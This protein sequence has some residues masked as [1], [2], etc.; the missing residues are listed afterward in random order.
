MASCITPQW[1]SYAPQ[2][3][4]TVNQSSSTDTSVTLSW[5]LEYISAY[6]ASSSGARAYTVTIDGATA[7]SGSY[8]INGVTGTRTIASGTKTVSKS[9][10]ARSVSF[11]VSFAFNLTWSGVRGNTKEASG[12]ISIGAKTS[13]TV[14]YNA[15]GGS[16]APGSQTKWYG[17]T[18]TLSSTRPSRTGYSFQGW[19]TSSGG[20]VSYSPGGSYTSNANVTLYAVW[21][22]NTYTVTFNA[23]G[24]SGGPGSQTKT[25]GV[26]LTI[27]STVPTR[28]NYSF[29]G[30]G[31]SSGATSVAYSPGSTYSSNANITLYAIW[32]LSYKKPRISNVS[33]A[34]CTSDKTLSE[35]GTYARLK[36]GWSCDRSVSSIAVRWES[37][38]GGSGSQTISASGTSG[39]VDQAIGSGKF[40]TESAYTI[41]VTVT[42]SGGYFVRNLLLNGLKLPFDVR[43]D[44]NGVAFG[45]PA[46]LAGVADFGF[47][48]MFRG[49]VFGNAFGLA[50]ISSQYKIPNNSNMNDYLTPGTY[51]IETNASSETMTNLPTNAAG[52]LIVCDGIG[53]TSYSTQY[54]YRNQIFIPYLITRGIYVRAAM[55]DANS[56]W[57]YNPWYRI[58]L[59]QV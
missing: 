27:S 56:A 58:N 11:G 31:T 5:T 14:S 23:N 41:Y 51:Y 29:V 59:T 13:Y 57:T 8:D 33:V 6:A 17:T 28:T 34:R 24:G 49:D 42:D 30:W 1:V 2:V 47:N 40:S 18:L 7:K 39:S 19:A 22:A 21:K 48:A 26:N 46:E 37:S 35:T 36:F 38:T 25:Y 32:S 15:N 54:A 50:N 43:S 16:G 55:S 53:T 12:S 4:L 20:G 10:A 45:K 52:K 44:A 3:R 9:T